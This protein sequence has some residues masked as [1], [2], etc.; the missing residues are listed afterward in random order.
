MP[1]FK[2]RRATRHSLP[3]RPGRFLDAHQC[4]FAVEAMATIRRRSLLSL[5]RL[6]MIQ[7]L[8]VDGAVFDKT[9]LSAAEAFEAEIRRCV[10]HWRAPGADQ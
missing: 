1:P 3:V 8:I 7:A 6:T 10:A 5:Q 4:R 2:L 9:S